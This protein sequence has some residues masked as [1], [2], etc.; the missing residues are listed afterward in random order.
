M[1]PVEKGTI[2]HFFH[3]IV[4]TAQCRFPKPGSFMPS[5]LTQLFILLYFSL[6]PQTRVSKLLP[7]A[8]LVSKATKTCIPVVGHHDLL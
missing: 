1:S 5:F 7:G 2:R 4:G 3:F 6:K 8:P